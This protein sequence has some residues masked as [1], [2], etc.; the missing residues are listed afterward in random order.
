MRGKAGKPCL[1]HC[2][3]L[4]AGGGGGGILWSRICF[5]GKT[6]FCWP[7]ICSIPLCFPEPQP[8][9]LSPRSASKGSYSGDPPPI[10]MSWCPC[11]QVSISGCLKVQLGCGWWG[12]G[13]SRGT[14][15]QI[16]QGLLFGAF[17]RVPRIAQHL[18][19]ERWLHV[20]TWGWDLP[21][22]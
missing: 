18:P 16:I 3:S 10:S 20:L 15:I 22:S 1:I 9:S 7:L 6:V 19:P 5:L 4:K 21:C 13:R 17:V 8:H 14:C 12:L 2:I 11:L